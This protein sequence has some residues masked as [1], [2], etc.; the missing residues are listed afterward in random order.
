LE[1]LALFF[2]SKNQNWNSYFI[3]REPVPE[4]IPINSKCSRNFLEL[5]PK[6]F[7]TD[8]FIFFLSKNQNRNGYFIFG[9][10][11]PEPILINTKGSRPWFED[12]T[13][14]ILSGLIRKFQEI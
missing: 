3:F 4:P 9:E 6:L 1:P 11:V 12:F 5:V 10:P 2:L 13:Y 7:G 8:T 14:S